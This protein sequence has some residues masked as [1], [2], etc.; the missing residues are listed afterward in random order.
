MKINIVGTGYVGLISGLCFAE[1]GHD[2]LCIDSDAEKI[3]KLK[4]GDAPFFEPGLKEMLKETN[5]KFSV[6]GDECDVAI[7]C[8]GT[9]D[10][11]AKAVFDVAKANKDVKFF[12]VKSTVPVGTC[13]KIAAIITG[14]VISCPEFL[15][16]GSAIEDTKK[17]HRI[18]AGVESE[19][20]KDVISRLYEGRKIFFTDL[21][22]S[23]LIKYASNTFLATKISLIN[24][25]ANY[26]EQ[27]GANIKDVSKG[28]GLDPRIGEHFLEAGIGYGGSCL[29]KDVKALKGD[30]KILSAVHDVN[31]AQRLKILEKL[32]DLKG[33]KVAV[34][35][36]SFKPN[37]DD[38]REAPSTFIIEKLKTGGCDIRCYDPQAKH[39]LNVYESPYKTAQ[40]CDV[41]LFLTEWDEFKNLD[42][43]KLRAQMKGDTLVDARNIFD[44]LKAREAGFTYLSLG[45]V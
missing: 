3:E 22:S 13:K 10:D 38:L 18:I 21:N 37:T 12:I 7:C 14:E 40:G 28:V 45:R 30:F 5:A 36:L 4:H 2:V 31:E 26:C 33:K 23:E 35:G 24:E 32:G 1:Q 16:Q 34:L 20:G 15:R 17:P 6:K 39:E 42:L 43:K 25:F 41:V 19:K 44:Y 27:V 29:P 9:P 11:D 8:V